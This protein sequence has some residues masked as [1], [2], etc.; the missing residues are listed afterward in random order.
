M[1]YAHIIDGSSAVSLKDFDPSDSHGLDRKEAE[2]KTAALGTEMGEMLELLYAAGQKSLLLL[3]QGIDTSGKDGT[4]RHL[5]SYVNVQSCR[6]VPFKTPTMEELSHDFLWR[7]HGKTP[8]RGQIAIFNRSHY[9]D[10]LIVR[11]H[12]LVPE[13]VWRKRYAHI[14]HFENL[15]AD[16]DTI[17][18]KFF[19]HISKDEQEERLLARQDDPTKFWKLNVGDWQEREL[20]NDYIAAYEEAMKRCSSPHAPWHV[21]PANRKWFRNLAITQTI[22]DA[23][24]PYHGPWMDHLK[25]IGEDA[26]REIEAYR[27]LQKAD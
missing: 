24:R 19:L 5:L 26:K 17:L 12:K 8:G 6:V 10:V 14:N 16:S 11:V 9:E 4:I 13:E 18:L 20:W 27:T 2:K 3:L 25:E 7:V 22:V 1:S 15:L 23:L 21:I